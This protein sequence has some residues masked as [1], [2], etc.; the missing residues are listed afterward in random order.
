MQ[1]ENRKKDFSAYG[2]SSATAN[3]RFVERRCDRIALRAWSRSPT[4][5][6]TIQSD[7]ETIRT[8]S[9]TMIRKL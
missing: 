9:E 2:S 3:D 1:I 7:S 6:E 4:D 5:S 8:D